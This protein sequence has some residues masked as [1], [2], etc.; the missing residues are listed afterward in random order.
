AFAAQAT[1]AYLGMAAMLTLFAALMLVVARGRYAD[2]LEGMRQRFGHA[3]L[4][5]ELAATRGDLLDLIGETSIGFAMFDADR[6]L[7]LW[8]A[9]FAQLAGCPPEAL[10]AGRGFA[11]IAA[12]CAQDDAAGVERRMR[13]GRWVRVSNRPTERGGL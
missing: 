6:K 8:S 12:D 2:F 4:L 9:N 11:D 3:A 5:R 13:D 10:R 7:T 1:A